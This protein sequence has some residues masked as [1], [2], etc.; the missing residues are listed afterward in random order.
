LSLAS[1]A[2]WLILV[3]TAARLHEGDSLLAP[4]LIRHNPVVSS[5][6]TPISSAP[7]S[8]AMI[9]AAEKIAV[10]PGIGSWFRTKPPDVPRQ[11]VD[12]GLKARYD[13]LERQGL[14]PVP[15]YYIWNAELVK[16]ACSSERPPF[17]IPRPT[18]R[19]S[20]TR[21]TRLIRLIGC[22]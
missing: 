4:G 12:A 13:D 18:C 2:L 7:V 15:S 19:N 10:G 6:D 17:E 3:E 14:Y 5:A 9:G 1:I 21:T 16:A 8:Q 11:P 22:P 20:P